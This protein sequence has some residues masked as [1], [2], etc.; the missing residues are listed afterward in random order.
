MG[1]AFL[2]VREVLNEVGKFRDGEV[3]KLA[4]EDLERELKVGGSLIDAINRA[5]L[6]IGAKIEKLAFAKAVTRLLE[7]QPAEVTED[8]EVYLARMQ[9]VFR[10]VNKARRV[11]ER[12]AGT[13]KLDAIV[14]QRARL[15]A[16]DHPKTATKEQARIVLDEI[17]A[18][19]DDSV[20]SEAIR[21]AVL[22][23]RRKH[24]LHSD[25]AEF[26]VNHGAFLEGIAGLKHAIRVDNGTGDE[27]FADPSGVIAGVDPQPI[28][29]LQPTGAP[30]IDTAAATAAVAGSSLAMV[31]ETS[32][33]APGESVTTAEE[34][35]TQ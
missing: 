26:V 5:A 33:S 16:M 1:L 24:D 22:S 19:L 14:D 4:K 30:S 18:Q 20:E 17:E 2:A 6:P 9:I 29:T 23:L 27:P 12:A 28:A 11:A 25:P 31:D 21:N 7:S 8:V 13:Q 34:L 15:F 35:P 10:A 32:A 3:P